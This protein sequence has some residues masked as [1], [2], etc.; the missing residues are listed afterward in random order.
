MTSVE[1]VIAVVEAFNGL[2]IPH[3]LVGSFST[4][5][6]GIPRSAQDADFVI[7]LG[8]T[9]IVAIAQRLGPRFRLDPKRTRGTLTSAPRHEVIVVD[10]PFRVEIFLLTDAPHD[11]ERFRRRRRIGFLGREV[12]LP[13]AED[14]IVTKLHWVAMRGQA[15]DRQDVIDVIAVQDVDDN[16]DWEYIQSRCD[17]HLIRKHLDEVRRSIPTL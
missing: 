8:E 9:S 5:Y 14:V 1:V 11:Q 16:L 15:K 13:T 2:G 10:N 12:W 3:M 17:H 4:N 7:D 6:Y